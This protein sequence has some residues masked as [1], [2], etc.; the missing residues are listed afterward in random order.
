MAQYYPRRMGTIKEL[1]K[2]YAPLFEVYDDEEEER[3]EALKMYDLNTLPT[4]CHSY[5]Y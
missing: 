4:F 1:K 5:V 2:A 3:F